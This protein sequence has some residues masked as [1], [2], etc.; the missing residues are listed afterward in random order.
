M[1]KEIKRLRKK[2][3]ILSSGITFTV[4]FV[5]LLVL[6]IL[7]HLSYSNELKTA[8]DMLVQTA[9]S[10]TWD[11]ASEVLV[12][13]EME[14]DMRMIK[15]MGCNFVRLVHYPHNKR[16]L[17]I[18]DRLGLMVSEEP[19]LWWSDTSLSEVAGG[20]TEVLR[21][22]ILR[23]RNHPCIVFWLCFNECEFT[24]EFLTSS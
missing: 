7:M 8:S 11:M 5:M 12:L 19:G 14:T 15:E 18:A 21:R 23:D 13:D 9:F 17:D 6:N 1:D 16:I 4:I 3:F 22:T 20:S 24:E 2:F 10:N